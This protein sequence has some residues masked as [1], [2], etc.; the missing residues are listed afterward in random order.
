MSVTISINGNLTLCHKN[1]GGYASATVPD[2]CKTPGI[3]S[4]VPY[5]NFA[6]STNLSKGTKTIKVDGG[7]M[8]ANKGSEFS[9][10]T[11]DEAGTLGGVKS[12]V[13]MKEATWLSYSFDVKMEGKGACRLS[14][15]MLMN[16]GNTFC[17][18]GV[19]QPDLPP[20]MSERC[21]ELFKKIIE[22]IFRNK[23]GFGNQGTHG[24][25]HRFREQ[26]NGINGPGTDVWKR[27]EEVIKQQQ[28]GLRDRLND[29]ARNFCGDPPEGAWYW[30]TKPVPSEKDWVNPNATNYTELAV[31]GAATAGAAYIIYRVVRFIPSLFPPLWPTIPANAACP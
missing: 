19:L 25:K 20:D 17:M 28:K 21:K 31:K 30:A 15:K 14:D 11:G 24:L 10:S 7:N 22:F 4:P 27:H 9:C 16:H 3:P 18:E 8:A 29:F 23:K 5:P 26:I 12:G 13:N 1:S 2:I 6:T